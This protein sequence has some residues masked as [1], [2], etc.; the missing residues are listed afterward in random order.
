MKKILKVISLLIIP[1]IFT[2]CGEETVTYRTLSQIKES[3]TINI[4]YS[5]DLYPFMNKDTNPEQNE[6]DKNND[7]ICCREEQL[8]GSI[9]KRNGLQ[10]NLI[11]T[12][13]NEVVNL[14]LDGSADIALGKIEKTESD[15]FKVN[16]TLI[17][18]NEEPYIIT[19]KDVNIFSL[20][21]FKNKKVALITDSAI[22]KLIKPKI[23]TTASDIKQYKRVETALN[24]LLEYNIDAII[25]Y[26]NEALK[27][28]EE[29]AENVQVTTLADG[30]VLNYVGLVAKGNNALLEEVNT[31][32]NEYFYP[33]QEE[34]TL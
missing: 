31:A 16:Q 30:D 19:S 11:K 14:I 25:C 6:I 17:Y 12:T 20:E 10:V 8:I 1:L 23:T 18:A 24:Q 4:A 3:G 28:L 15:K 7:K 32:I 27:I 13:R 21:D 2:G 9:V 22:E 26:K 34:E 33:P 29:N 5:T